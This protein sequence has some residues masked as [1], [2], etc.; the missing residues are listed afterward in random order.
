MSCALSWISWMMVNAQYST[1]KSLLFLQNLTTY[2][3]PTHFARIISPDLVGFCICIKKPNTR[4]RTTRRWA[5]APWTGYPWSPAPQVSELTYQWWTKSPIPIR[6]FGIVSRFWLLH[7]RSELLKRLS[8]CI[9]LTQRFSNDL[10]VL[11]DKFLIYCY[12]FNCLHFLCSHPMAP[13][14]LWV[15]MKD[16]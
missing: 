7:L 3:I 12:S 13:M 4:C 6:Y 14:Y 2:V 8:R 1:P 16:L 10:I 9:T 11:L 5:T 15:Y